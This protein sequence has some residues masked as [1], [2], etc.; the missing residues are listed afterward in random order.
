ML[1]PSIR[2]DSGIPSSPGVAVLADEIA[3]MK[4]G[5][6]IEEHAIEQQGDDADEAELGR[7]VDRP[8]RG[9]RIIGSTSVI[10]ASMNSTLR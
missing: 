4:D 1:K 2:F 5:L 6:G 7:R 3:A 9:Q 10:V 8:G